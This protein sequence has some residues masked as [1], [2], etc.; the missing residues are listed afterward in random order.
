MIPFEGRLGLLI[1]DKRFG[2]LIEL[3]GFD[4]GPDMGTDFS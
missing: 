1:A 4:A 3:N 2:N